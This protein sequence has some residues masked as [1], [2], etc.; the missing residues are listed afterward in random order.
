MSNSPA[1]ITSNVHHKPLCTPCFKSSYILLIPL[2]IP[3]LENHLWGRR[4]LR[5]LNAE[6]LEW[7]SPQQHQ[8]WITGSRNKTQAIKNP[9]CQAA[10][11]SQEHQGWTT[12][13]SSKLQRTP[14]KKTKCWCHGY[15]LCCAHM[16]QVMKNFWCTD[17]PSSAY[18]GLHRVLLLRSSWKPLSKELYK[19]LAQVCPHWTQKQIRNMWLT[20]LPFFKVLVFPSSLVLSSERKLVSHARKTH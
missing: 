6:S 13:P 14:G 19:L 18:H 5:M 11:V 1:L 7:R 16:V 15:G 8:V 9:A 10:L 20:P 17:H 12:W 4:L 3:A 2:I